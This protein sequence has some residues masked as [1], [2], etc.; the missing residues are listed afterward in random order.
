MCA[1]CLVLAMRATMVSGPG[2]L[3]PCCCRNSVYAGT[4][5]WTA[6]ILQVLPSYRFINPNLAAQMR[7]ALSN[8]DWKTGSRRPGELE[9]TLRTSDVAVC[10]SSDSVSSRVRCCSAANN[11]TFSI[12]IAA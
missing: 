6:I 1:T 12:A 4:A 10:Y 9:M 11:R 7:T 5:S 8:I 2:R 3:Y